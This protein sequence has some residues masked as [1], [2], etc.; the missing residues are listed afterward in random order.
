MKAKVKG[1]HSPDI[2]DLAS[3]IPN[4]AEKFSLLL[5]IMVGPADSDGE[6]SFDIEVCTP[7]WLIETYQKNDVLIGR[8]YLIVFEYNYDR[9]ISRIVSYISSC[10]GK[11]W[12]E[13][14]EK[15]GR[16]GLWE[17]EDYQSRND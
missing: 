15:I 3:Y 7:Q 11:T 1:I 17:F 12:H 5:Q 4:D 6:E 13:L 10:E 9:I 16:L 8:H 14:A 2:F